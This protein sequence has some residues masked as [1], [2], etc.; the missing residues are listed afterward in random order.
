MH[1][2]EHID[3]FLAPASHPVIEH[4]S[5]VRFGNLSPS[6]QELAFAP[7]DF[8]HVRDTP[9]PNW[10][11]LSTQLDLGALDGLRC[12]PSPGNERDTDSLE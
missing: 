10:S 5:S 4:C 8:S 7:Q 1:D 3:V 2:S 12:V 9:S 6:A 11:F